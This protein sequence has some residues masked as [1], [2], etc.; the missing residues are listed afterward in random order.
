MKET[1][2]IKKLAS[3]LALVLSTRNFRGNQVTAV[4]TV[5]TVPLALPEVES[6]IIYISEPAPQVQEQGPEPEPEHDDWIVMNRGWRYHYEAGY[7]VLFQD[8]DGTP[9]PGGEIGRI[10]EAAQNGRFILHD[11]IPHIPPQPGEYELLRLARLSHCI[12]WGGEGQ[13][14]INNGRIVMKGGRP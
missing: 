14:A 13:I 9:L 4:T 6:Q 12:R 10:Y 11:L 8:S 5:E 2:G 7:G 3:V 1:K